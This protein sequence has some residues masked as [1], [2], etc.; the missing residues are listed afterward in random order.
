MP[1]PVTHVPE[2]LCHL[3]GWYVPSVIRVEVQFGR[4]AVR[5]VIEWQ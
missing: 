5:T 1:R 2:H 4:A 3:Y